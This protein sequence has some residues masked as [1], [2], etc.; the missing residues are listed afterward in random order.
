MGFIVVMYCSIS[1]RVT[2]LRYIFCRVLVIRFS[3]QI[4]NS[5]CCIII[6]SLTK[7][8]DSY[9][10]CFIRCVCMYFSKL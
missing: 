7:D 9:C 3:H 8:L 10:S 2:Y 1:V 5:V 6:V 4:T